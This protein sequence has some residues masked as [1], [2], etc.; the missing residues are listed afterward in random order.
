[1]LSVTTLMFIFIATAFMG[2]QRRAEFNQSVRNF[3]AML[4]TIISETANGSYQSSKECTIFGGQ[5]R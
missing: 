2:R 1:M 4:Q 5:P 3:E